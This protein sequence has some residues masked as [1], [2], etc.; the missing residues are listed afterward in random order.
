MT[1]QVHVVF[2]FPIA[3]AALWG[4]LSSTGRAEFRKVEIPFFEKPVFFC[5]QRRCKNQVGGRRMG[6]QHQA[7]TINDWKLPEIMKAGAGID[8]TRNSSWKVDDCLVECAE[9][10]Q[11]GK[12]VGTDPRSK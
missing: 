10:W 2:R 7:T 6:Y 3:I 5:R 4:V 9:A 11:I 8:P 1:G 12:N